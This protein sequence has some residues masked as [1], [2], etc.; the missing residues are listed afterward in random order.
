MSDSTRDLLVRGIAAAKAGD[1]DEARFYL[2]WLLRSDA[3]LDQQV[4]AW[5]WL[6]EITEG[7][8]QKRDYL[9]SILAAEPGHPE[10]RRKLALLDGR[11]K[12]ADLVDPDRMAPRAAGDPRAASTQRFECRR[13]GARMRYSAERDALS[14]DYCG[15]RERPTRA[16]PAAD[17]EH[18]FVVALATARGHAAPVTVHTFSC[19]GCGKTF[20]LAPEVLSLTCPHCGSTYALRQTETRELILPMELIPMSVG[21]ADVR[22][23]VL[24][25]LGGNGEPNGASVEPVGVYFPVWAFDFTGQVGW[26]CQVE[27]NGRQARYSGTEPVLMHDVLAPGDRLPEPAPEAAV[28]GF[29]LKGLVPYD[30]HYLADW[31]A[32][33]YTVSVSDASLAARTHALRRARAGIYSQLVG[34]VQNLTLDSSGLYVDS[35]KLLLGPLWMVRYSIG[36]RE[37]LAVVNGQTGIV[38]GRPPTHGLLGWLKGLLSQP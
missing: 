2:E 31:P 36:G 12:A 26:A 13:C 20:V 37:R 17:T 14:C 24:R 27:V 11:L 19:E 1:K 28:D 35:F 38:V 33:T 25:W 34:N 5:N 21:K 30:V 23:A 6:S 9:E 32:E 7:P 15:H 10:A 18:D 8:R 4:D 3:E 22:T 29:D 16:V